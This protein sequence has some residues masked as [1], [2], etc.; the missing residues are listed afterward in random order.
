MQRS[1]NPFAKVILIT[2]AGRGIGAA[3]AKAAAAE[4]HLVVANYRSES[5]E[6]EQLLSGLKD[7]I[8]IRADVSIAD[9]VQ[10]LINETLAHFGRIDCVINNA[11]I[12]EV[13]PIDRLDL[14]LFQK[15]L[16]A[17]LT[18]AFL[19]SQAAWPHMTRDG[20]RLIFMSS[21]A[22]RTGGGLSAAYAA[23]KGGVESLMHA[24]ASALR[25]HRITANAIAPAL[26]E[27]RMAD[28]IDVG[29]TEK[30][31]LGRMGRAEELWPATRM[32]IETEYL[33]GQTIHVDAGRYMT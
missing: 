2:G 12:G 29:P 21:A 11:G 26:I 22:A 20:G 30:L 9:D 28:A 15:T 33:T 24:Y 1:H 16:N 6:V 25:P 4:G 3:L 32:I 7:S 23:S 27:S 18:S 13:C 8:G 14:A 31:P 10:R 19:V 17:N 5:G